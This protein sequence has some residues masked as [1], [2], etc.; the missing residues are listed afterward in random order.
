M[1]LEKSIGW[2]VFF[3]LWKR[4]MV[5]DYILELIWNNETDVWNNAALEVKKKVRF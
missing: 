1:D 4:N 2:I 5:F 3:F